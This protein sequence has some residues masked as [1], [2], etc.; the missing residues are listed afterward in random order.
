MSGNS[1]KSAQ[2][3]KNGN[4]NESKKDEWQFRNDV[5]G[6][7]EDHFLHTSTD[8]ILRYTQ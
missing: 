4:W 1:N 8:F 2:T 3:N 6:K 7:N 5:K